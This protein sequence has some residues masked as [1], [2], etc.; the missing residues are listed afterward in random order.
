MVGL[1]LD[2]RTKN[3]VK[4]HTGGSRPKA[5]QVNRMMFFGWFPTEGTLAF[6]MYS[7]IN[8]DVFK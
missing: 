6:G 7:I 1:M 4:I 2:S 5:S 8:P 3:G